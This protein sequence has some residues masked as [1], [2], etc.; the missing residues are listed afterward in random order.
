MAQLLCH[1]LIRK[2][3]PGSSSLAA[4][5]VQGLQAHV[6]AD[7]GAA[8]AANAT[9]QHCTPLHCQ[10]QHCQQQQPLAS[11]HQHQQQ[12]HGCL[13][14]NVQQMRWSHSAACNHNHDHPHTHDHS[15]PQAATFEEQEATC[16]SCHDRFHRGGLVCQACDKIQP[17]DP[18]LTHF[19]ILG[20]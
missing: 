17:S 8:V 10:Q 6:A 5:A 12:Q 7:A 9:V 11:P 16:W 2:M 18:T 3:L 19:D 15:S 4:L 13:H 1:H 14:S 20:M